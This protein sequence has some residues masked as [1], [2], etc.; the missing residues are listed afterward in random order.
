[1]KDA[2]KG[3]LGLV[4]WASGEGLALWQKLLVYTE[5][6][7]NVLVVGGL[8][9]IITGLIL[10]FKLPFRLYSLGITV[11]LALG[12]F[13]GFHQIVQG[14]RVFFGVAAVLYLL[15]F[16]MSGSLVFLGAMLFDTL[17]GRKEGLAGEQPES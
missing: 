15:S 8:V 12:S 11:V 17:A 2:A 9:G 3:V 4:T 1:M 16:V 10:G 7:K 13:W 6:T 14:E 5:A